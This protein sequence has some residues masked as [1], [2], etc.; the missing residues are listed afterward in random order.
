MTPLLT[1]N[2]ELRELGVWNFTLPAWVVELADGRHLNVCPSA[3]ACAPI[4]YARNGTYLFPAVRAA[5]LD[6]L[7]QTMAP[8]RFVYDMSREVRR[9][10][11]HGHPHLPEVPRAHLHGDVAR[12]LDLGAPLV[13]IHDSGD[14][15]AEGYLSAWLAVAVMA[16]G[17]LFYAYT[18]E[19][20]L[21]EAYT[22]QAPP[23]FLWI[24]SLGGRQDHLVDR[25]TMR[26]ADV[27][28]DEAAITTAGYYSQDAHDLLSVVAPSLRIG[29]PANNIPHFQRRQAG[30]T[31]SAMQEERHPRQKVLDTPKKG[32]DK[33]D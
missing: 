6:N 19:V 29:I 18:K 13:R 1:R 14:F 5:H 9:L 7:R 23:N 3:G 24:Y 16:P 33:N 26:H 17:V 28:P 10:Q 30:R 4:C 8:G 20:S 21:L 12:L 31:F 22:W 11:P 2:S 15:Y 32:V 25:E 27:F